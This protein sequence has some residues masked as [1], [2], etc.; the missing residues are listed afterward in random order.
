MSA[1]YVPVVVPLQRLDEETDK[2]C[3]ERG[4]RVNIP[5]LL[6]FFPCRLEVAAV[7]ALLYEAYEVFYQGARGPLDCLACSVCGYVREEG[8][9][10]KTGQLFISASG[11]LQTPDEDPGILQVGVT[12]DSHIAEE[13]FRQT[14]RIAANTTSHR[15]T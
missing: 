12:G 5:D 14:I 3:A 6:I 7:R 8:F 13:G 15:F 2:D 11:T 1:D 9:H 4:A 10:M